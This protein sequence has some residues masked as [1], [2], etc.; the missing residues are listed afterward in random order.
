M[1]RDQAPTP[2]RS[3]S[4]ASARTW[5]RVDTTGKREPQGAPSGDGEDGP[6]DP[7][8]PPRTFAATTKQCSVSIALPGPTTA[9]HQPGVSW[10]GAV[11]PR[12]WASP[13]SA[14]RTRT[15]L[16]F[17]SSSRPHVS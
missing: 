3:A 15:A 16:D 5:S 12:T 17:A 6:V 4:R 9:S 13:V 14:C 7:W 1:T 10:P 11:G 2:S 8:Q